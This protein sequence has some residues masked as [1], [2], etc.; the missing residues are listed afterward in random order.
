[1]AQ[2]ENSTRMFENI[3]ITPDNENLKT[4]S[5]NLRK[6]N[7]TYHAPGTDHAAVVFNIANGPNAGKLIWSMGPIT[8]AH[9]DSRPAA[10]GYQCP[11]PGLRLPS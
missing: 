8:F 3:L 10:G 2:E 5:E 7:Q 11:G 1:M 9:L 6:H 4:L